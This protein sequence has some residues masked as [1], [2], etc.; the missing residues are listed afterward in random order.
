MKKR[1][2]ELDFPK[3]GKQENNK[4]V[5]WIQTKSPDT[6]REKRRWKTTTTNPPPEDPMMSF[7][8]ALPTE[9]TNLKSSNI[10]MKQKQSLCCLCTCI[11]LCVCV[12]VFIDTINSLCCPVLL[13]STDGGW[14]PAVLSLPCAVAVCAC[15]CVCV[16][17]G[18]T[19]LRLGR[20]LLFSLSH[21]VL[22]LLF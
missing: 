5:K 13:F 11:L 6:E 10:K 12:C 21:L 1:I 2:K 4:L 7:F 14:S 19:R 16:F 18:T 22:F 15:V 17:T 9:G 8:T 3:L 20:F